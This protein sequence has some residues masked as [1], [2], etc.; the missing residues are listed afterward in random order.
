M[1]K[2]EIIAELPKLTAEDRGD[3]LARLWQ[4]EEVAG[5]TSR[6]KQL[7]NE[8]QAAYDANPNAGSPWSEVEARLRRRA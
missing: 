8:A 4:M 3:I 5:P 6:E 1:S 2:A 7:L